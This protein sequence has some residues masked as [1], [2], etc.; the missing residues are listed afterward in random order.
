MHIAK[1]ARQ[2]LL[3]LA[4]AGALKVK[5]PISGLGMLGILGILAVLGVW[6]LGISG[7]KVSGL[8]V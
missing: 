3:L 2:H 1:L 8:W 6:G 7:F 4:A 5:A